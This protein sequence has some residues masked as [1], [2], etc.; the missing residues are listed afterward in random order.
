[1]QNIAFVMKEGNMGYFEVLDLPYS[2]FLSLLKHFQ[3][4][5]L[6][7]DEDYR[8]QLR[9]QNILKKT[10]PDWEEVRKLMRRS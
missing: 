5:E 3:M 8:K 7:K 1:M 2:I 10:E 9:M 4:F 6:M